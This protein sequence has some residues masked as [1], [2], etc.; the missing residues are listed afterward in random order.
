MMAVFPPS[1]RMRLLLA[2]VGALVA[3]GPVGAASDPVTAREAIGRAV[4]ARMGG[5]VAVEV[6]TLDMPDGAPDRFVD[7]T[8]DP[9]GRLGRAIRFSLIPARGSRVQATA[10][11]RVVGEYVVARRDLVRGATI[12]AGDVEV[13]RA[14]VIDTPLRRLPDGEQVVGSRVLRPLRADSVVLPGTVAI[15]RAVEPGDRITAVALVGDV[16]VSA[17]LRATDGGET[18][19][20]IRVVNTDTR[21]SLRGRIVGEGLVEVGYAR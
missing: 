2:I 19:D 16:R 20:V 18:G 9:A 12:E 6:L 7:A 1:F 11:L 17:E 14:E 13:R 15:R 4:V 8:P 3:A 10:T 21:R 5:D